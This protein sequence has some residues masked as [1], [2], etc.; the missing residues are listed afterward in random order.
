MGSKDP[1]RPRRLPN[2]SCT[3]PRRHQACPSHRVIQ[4]VLVDCRVAGEPLANLRTGVG[5]FYN[6][7]DDLSK[8]RFRKLS[9]T[10]APP[11]YDKYYESKAAW[12]LLLSYSN[13]NLES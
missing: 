8:T 10:I 9:C 2:K 1:K 12:D 3:T 4:I 7:D 13:R 11:W 6:F 5:L